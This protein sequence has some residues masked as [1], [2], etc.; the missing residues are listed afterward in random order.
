MDT[1]VVYPVKKYEGIYNDIFEL[2]GENAVETLFKNMAG[3]QVSFPKHLYSKEY[4]FVETS[5]IADT[6]ELKKMAIQFGY[7][8]RRFLQIIREERE[9]MGNG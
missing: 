8:E 9:V 4:I 3:M 6:Y 7:S 5:E 2:L 1:D